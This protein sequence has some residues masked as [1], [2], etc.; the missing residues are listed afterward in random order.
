[1]EIEKR[2]SGELSFYFNYLVE[3]DAI[4]GKNPTATV[5]KLTVNALDN[6]DEA[7]FSSV[8]KIKNYQLYRFTSLW[9]VK[10]LLLFWHAVRHK[11]TPRAL[12]GEFFYR[13]PYYIENLR[14]THLHAGLAFDFIHLLEVLI[15][16]FEQTREII[17]RLKLKRGKRVIERLK[18][19]F[20]LYEILDRRKLSEILT[21]GNSPDDLVRAQVNKF[22]LGYPINE[23]LYHRKFSSHEFLRRITETLSNE[24]APE[25]Q[26]LAAVVAIVNLNQLL[27]EN[28]HRSD[29]LGLQ[30]FSE[31]LIRKNPIKMV[32]TSLK[33][34]TA[35]KAYKLFFTKESSVES[36]EL[37]TFPSKSGAK[38]WYRFSTKLQEEKNKKDFSLIFHFPKARNAKEIE[39]IEKFYRSTYKKCKRFANILKHNPE[40][41]ELF[42]GIDAASQEYWTPAWVFAPLYSFWRNYA[43]HYIR[44]LAERQ[45]PIKFTFHAGEDFVELASGIRS[46]YEALL[47]LELDSGDRI[48][49]GLALATDPES[50]SLRARNI[51]ISPLHY[52]FSLLW[53]N[54]VSFKHP[55][56]KKYEKFFLK[57]L[58]WLQEELPSF[59]KLLSRLRA[60]E[61]GEEYALELNVTLVNLYLSLKYDFVNAGEQSLFARY[62]QAPAE[63]DPFAKRVRG[64]LI[65]F[66]RDYRKD[67]KTGRVPKV[68]LDPVL[69]QESTLPFE[70]QVE[71]LKALQEITLREVSKRGVVIEACPSSN[72]L[73]RG[74]IDYKEHLVVKLKEKIKRKELRVSLNTDNPLTFS[75]TLVEEFLLINEALPEE[76]REPV[77]TALIENARH[78]KFDCR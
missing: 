52:L 65:N 56:V 30:Y 18:L 16:N 8:S 47:F 71:L 72:F 17:K 19:T 45:K 67:K 35:A 21:K 14:D 37:R 75:N 77:I 31:E 20:Q 29:Y 44:Q 38:F 55:E 70:E 26:K 6:L 63:K 49:H 33:E 32:S 40:L 34:N 28:T 27:Q 54:Y 46:V 74:L 60:H 22:N 62:W 51:R 9:V 76:D 13:L 43:H 73:I 61:N 59:R 25:G 2:Y 57:E 12:K 11:I 5:V 50:Y 78:F 4:K 41:T 53:L 36:F 7:V 3:E 24:T 42:C 48:G 58:L 39:E 15:K 23:P 10:E 69:R 68:L 66:F 1:M 64:A